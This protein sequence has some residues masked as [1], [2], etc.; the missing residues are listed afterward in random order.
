MIFF[1]LA[2]DMMRFK[3]INLTHC[4]RHKLSIICQDWFLIPVNDSMN[5]HWWHYYFSTRNT[6][7]I[8]CI[9]N[10]EKVS[11]RTHNNGGHSHGK[12]ARQWNKIH[13]G[14]L[15]ISKYIDILVKYCSGGERKRGW[16]FVHILTDCA[17]RAYLPGT[18][19]Q[20]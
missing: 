12:N 14:I 2:F 3:Q 18:R 8:I 6:V 1:L 20:Q 7:A 5:V 10:P 4:K 9:I 17:A 11:L 16:R 13:R 15:V 19:C